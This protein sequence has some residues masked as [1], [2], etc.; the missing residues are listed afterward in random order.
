MLWP[1]RD[2]GRHSGLTGL[3]RLAGELRRQRYAKAWLL[4]GSSRYAWALLLAGIAVTIGYGRGR[5]RWLLSDVLQLP[6]DWTRGHPILLADR[7]LA[8]HRIA[9]EVFLQ[10]VGRPMPGW[11]EK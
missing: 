9:A 6:S 2:P 3:L 11:R 4:H 5:Q 7:L 8:T 1:E 10:S